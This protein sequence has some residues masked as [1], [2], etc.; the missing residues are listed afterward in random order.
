MTAVRQK[1]G[2]FY[3]ALFLI[4]LFVFEEAIYGRLPISPLVYITAKTLSEVVL[5]ALLLLIIMIRMAGKHIKPYYP[6]RFDIFIIIFII[7]A[8]ISSLLN[9][10]A[11]F[12]SALTLRTMLRY[13]AIYYIV[14]LSKW[15]PTRRQLMLIMK[16][17]IWI[18]LFQSAIVIL[19]HVMG[20][21]FTE[22]YFSA[23]KAEI[24]IASISTLINAMTHKLGSGIGT[25]G[26]SATLS[27]FL[28]LSVV[29]ILAVI[30]SAK[31][32][33]K[34]KWWIA[35]FFI[36]VGIFYSYKRG[37]L[38]LAILAPF[39]IAWILGNKKILK[40]YTISGVIVMFVFVMLLL[41]KGDSGLVKAKEVEISP[42]Q[43][44]NQI[45]NKDY[46]DK[47]SRKS[48]G[49]MITEV[50]PEVLS[51]F[52]LLGYG[53]DEQNAKN[54]LASKGG[55]FAKLVSWG[56]FDDVYIVS[57]LVYYGP[58]GL[59]ILLMAFSDIYRKAKYLI[60]G[61]N[62]EYRTLAVAVMVILIFTLLSSFIE[63]VIEFRAFSFILWFFAGIVVSIVNNQHLLSSR[64]KTDERD[65]KSTM[66]RS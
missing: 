15:V 52:K 32:K 5:Y 55:E 18:A 20:Q 27:M 21:A 42:L 6:T 57:T 17:I 49:W 36:T 66:S 30:M 54:I 44:L 29:L 48:R 26:K 23:A 63:R 11:V 35:Y 28:L 64:F 10:G 31:R 59:L 40:L 60:Y 51:S 50:A 24:N 8:L 53:P 39:V 65:Q 13:I 38:L 22:A 58:V 41:S 45:F 34:W 12:E 25:F 19:Q 1:K 2:I 16:I 3:I 62:G 56:A 14:V 7:F 4:T 61:L 9:Q 37:A 47:S 43:S 46:W 33:N